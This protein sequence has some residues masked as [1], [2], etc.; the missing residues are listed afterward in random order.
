[1]ASIADGATAGAGL[2]VDAVAT[3]VDCLASAM[4]RLGEGSFCSKDF[5]VE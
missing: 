3:G 5:K 2:D 1:M 4:V